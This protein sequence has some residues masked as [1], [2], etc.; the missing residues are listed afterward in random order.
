MGHLPNDAPDIVARVRNASAAQ[1]RAY[2]TRAAR[3]ALARHQFEDPRLEA[4]LAALDAGRLGATPERAAV[5]QLVEELDEIAWDEQDRGAAQEYVTAFM[6]ARAAA[7]A[8]A[9][10]DDD[11]S[12]AAYDAAYEANAALEDVPAL[13]AALEEA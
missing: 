6:R 2:A 4:A 1:Q 3:A 8:A 10:L 7:A 13:R 11:P 9:A 5:E 12:T